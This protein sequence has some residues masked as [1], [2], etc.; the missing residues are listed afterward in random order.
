MVPLPQF[1]VCCLLGAGLLSTAAA[2]QLPD[3]RQDAELRD[4]MRRIR[5]RV[6]D[7]IPAVDYPDFAAA[8]AGSLFI[9][10][11]DQVIGVRLGTDIKAYPVEFLNGREV[12]ND[13]LGGRPIAV[14]W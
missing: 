10:E 2:A 11:S 6:Y 1:A 3:Q 13:S 9:R 8:A 5:T 12:V 7:A 14:T 4:L